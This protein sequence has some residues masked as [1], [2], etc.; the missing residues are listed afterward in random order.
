MTSPMTVDATVVTG[1]I[2]QAFFGNSNFR[3]LSSG[4]PAVTIMYHFPSLLHSLF[5]FSNLD[6]GTFYL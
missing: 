6:I 1:R 4:H 2:S 5:R 3:R